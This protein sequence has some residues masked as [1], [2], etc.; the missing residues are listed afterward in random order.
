MLDYDNL[1]DGLNTYNNA[2]QKSSR[3]LT[4]EPILLVWD[5]LWNIIDY[6]SVLKV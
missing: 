4:W 1:Y 3:N 6:K 2:D 5:I